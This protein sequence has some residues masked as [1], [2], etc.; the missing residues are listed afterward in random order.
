MYIW[1]I[2]TDVCARLAKNS[3][4]SF[5]TMTFSVKRW[6][7]WFKVLGHTCKLKWSSVWSCFVFC[8]IAHTGVCFWGLQPRYLARSSPA[9]DIFS[10]LTEEIQTT[11]QRAWGFPFWV[12]WSLTCW[13]ASW[14]MWLLLC[15]VSVRWLVRSR[16]SVCFVHSASLPLLSPGT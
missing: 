13:E 14:L 16:M 15:S 8:F 6:L 7:R 3:A 4:K 10:A 2:K 9:S 1:H 11:L 5:L 12:W